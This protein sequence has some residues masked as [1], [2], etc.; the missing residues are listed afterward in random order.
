[1]IG[2]LAL[3]LQYPFVRYALAVGVFDTYRE[4]EYLYCTLRDARLV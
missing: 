2:T 4:G 3:Y 1:M